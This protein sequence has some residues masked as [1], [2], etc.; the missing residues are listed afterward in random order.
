MKKIT[1]IKF[2]CDFC[3]Y[4]YKENEIAEHENN[5]EKN[6]K[7]RKCKSCRNLLSFERRHNKYYCLIQ[8]KEMWGFEKSHIKDCDDYEMA[9]L[10]DRGLD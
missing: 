7:N 10:K 8:K 2:F 3:E 6:P 5:C 4:S 9:S 1:E